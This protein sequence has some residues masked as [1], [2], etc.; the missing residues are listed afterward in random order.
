MLKPSSLCKNTL[1]T[2]KKVNALKQKNEAHQ[3]ILSIWDVRKLGGSSKSRSSSAVRTKLVKNKIFKWV[4]TSMWEQSWY[5]QDREISR[6]LDENKVGR[7]TRSWN[8]SLL[9]SGQS[10]G[11]QWRSFDLNF[12]LS[13]EWLL[14]IGSW[15]IVSGKF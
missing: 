10:F 12:W 3:K 15:I 8:E 4:F 5:K 11:E 14:L 9:G 1:W 7:K 13:T 6:Y 2:V